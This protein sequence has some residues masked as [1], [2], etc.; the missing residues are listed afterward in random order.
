MAGN[1]LS[2]EGYSELLEKV[3]TK[4]FLIAA[5]GYAAAR[6]LAPV[7][8][9]SNIDM[10]H[11][12]MELICIYIALSSFLII[13]NSYGE[14]EEAYHL[15]GFGLLAVAVFDSFH[16]FYWIAAKSM[17][18][19]YYDLRVKYWII[20]RLVEAFVLAAVSMKLGKLRLNKWTGLI[21]ALAGSFGLSLLLLLFPGL[22]P[23][24]QNENGLTP[25]KILLEYAI[26]G[27]SV[28]SLIN[29]KDELYNENGISYK[30][31]FMSLIFVIPAETAFTLYKDDSSFYKFYGH[32]MKII[33]YYYLYIAVYVSSIKYPY[34]KLAEAYEK[35]E[36]K[37]IKIKEISDILNDT[38]DALPIGIMNYESD[39]RIKYMNKRLEE[40]LACDRN[41]IYG[42]TAEEFLEIFPTDD[43]K[44]RDIFDLTGKSEKSPISTIRTYKNLHN[45]YV[46][47]SLTSHVMKNRVTVYFY[48]VKKE[49]EIKNFHLQTQ[50]I[51][52]AVNNCVL[53]TDQDNKIILYNE[54]FRK[55]F[56]I[57]DA[58]L[59]GMPMDSF[60]E[61]INI[62]VKELPEEGRQ[63]EPNKP[64][65]VS[66]ITFKGN[67][68]DL[69]VNVDLIK[70]VEDEIIGA[71][72]VF[73]D[74]TD[75]RRQEYKMQQQEKLALIGQ[76]AAGIIHEIKNPLATIKG[77]S[78][79]IAAKSEGDKIK[80]YAAVINV[81]IDDVTKVVNEFLSFAKPKPTVKT[82]TSINKI[83]ESMQLITETQCYTKNIKTKFL[84]SSCNMEITA[85]DIKIKQVL[86]NM[87]EN[88]IAAMENTEMP[89][90][91]ISTCYDTKTKEGIIRIADNGIGM[92][93]EVLKK[94][95]TPFFTTKEKGTGLGL[96]I[97]Y[98]I[99][100]EHNGRIE[101]DSEAGKGTEFRVIFT[102]IEN[103][104]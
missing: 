6:I 48:E 68:K 31:I 103:L 57:Q 4:G 84:Y 10:V 64:H 98:Q 9:Q 95:G 52:N 19:E 78:Q 62:K 91:V 82:R 70:N 11:T 89:Q 20:G 94:I 37:N 58:D 30:Y 85:D 51:L 1:S 61:R 38:L 88:A 77:L 17:P 24:M 44:D 3:L 69:L 8:W 65:E 5:A 81:S 35:L 99:M 23:A 101:V 56:E 79:L 93:S 49:Q 36:E 46:K 97:C 104:I 13:W 47:L 41:S 27:L 21:C 14:T 76:M 39:R 18:G 90:L 28:F 15:I 29:L 54:A 73:T 34:K 74:I 2:N 80:E 60:R 16:T 43:Q 7:L 26:I 42:L 102:Q 50:T 33:C 22:L 12:I 83:V 32:F 87:T 86:L 72:S 53:M 59:I 75:L 45:E 92:D 100:N 71:I 67:K 66:V 40:I 55:T 96:G 63:E 25:I